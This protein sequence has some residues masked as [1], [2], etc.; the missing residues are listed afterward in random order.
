MAIRTGTNLGL[1]DGAD[2]GDNYT[3]AGDTLLRGLDCLVMP[4]AVDILNTP[5]VTPA[6]GATY[7]IG[8]SPTGAWAGRPGQIAR[9]TVDTTPDVW[10]F[11]PAKR[12]WTAM[13]RV[14]VAG[15][16]Y[17]HNGTGWVNLVSLPVFADQATAGAGGVVTGELFRTSAGALMVKT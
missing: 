10:E 1:M 2:E 4:V 17:R 14:G 6:D 15:V 13:V 16:Q 11:Y 3:S 12:G 7:L 9:W 5:P 8:A